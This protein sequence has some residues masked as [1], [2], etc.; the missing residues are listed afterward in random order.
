[1]KKLSIFLLII[2]SVFS[3]YK[4]VFAMI[5]CDR[6][7]GGINSARAVSGDFALSIFCPDG[8]TTPGTYTLGT[9]DASFIAYGGMSMTT[10]LHFYLANDGGSLSGSKD[11]I[12]Q[13]VTPNELNATPWANGTAGVPSPVQLVFTG[14]QCEY[15]EL[16]SQAWQIK[17][18][19][20]N[21]YFQQAQNW[22]RAWGVAGS[23]YVAPVDGIAT[24]TTPAPSSSVPYNVNFT[25]TY[26]NSGT[27]GTIILTATT[28]TPAIYSSTSATITTGNGVAYSL[29]L[30]LSPNQTYSYTIEMCDY[31]GYPC[32]SPTSPVSFSTNGLTTPLAPV[33]TPEPCTWTDFSTWT[34]CLNNTLHDLFSPSS[35]SVNQ[36][37]NLYQNYIK[38]PPFGYVVAIQD[39][40]KNINNTSTSVFT[41][42][43]MPILNTYVFTPF[44]TALIWV[45]W[46]ALTFMLFKRLKDINL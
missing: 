27:Y 44:R 24:Q 40:L 45:L 19:N 8:V 14:T 1:M 38:K 6:T 34:G 29:D 41:L 28:G 2:F 13:D 18:S 10:P 46:V 21:L 20:A 33:W 9:L 4:N 39:A 32:L 23:G 11:C 36:F 26:N 25:G 35:E 5:P 43:S 22:S 37:S 17:P 30:V 15:T 3:F 12:S 42:Q 31:S 16:D 7:A